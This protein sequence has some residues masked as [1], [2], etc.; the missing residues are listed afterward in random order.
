MSL[1][2]FQF[3]NG[4]LFQIKVL[5]WLTGLFL[6]LSVSKILN[7]FVHCSL[8]DFPFYNFFNFDF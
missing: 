2:G 4:L 7:F 6:L 3:Y 5:H 8:F 1:M